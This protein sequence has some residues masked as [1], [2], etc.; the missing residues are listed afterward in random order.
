MDGNDNDDDLEWGPDEQRRRALLLFVAHSAQGF[1]RSLEWSWVLLFDALLVWYRI[2]SHQHNNAFYTVTII[3][4]L[5]G[6][7]LL[8]SYSSRHI[9]IKR[10]LA[11][12]HWQCHLRWWWIRMTIIMVKLGSWDQC[13]SLWGIKNSEM[14]VCDIFNDH[15]TTERVIFT[16]EDM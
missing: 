5:N 2:C 9:L 8:L 1:D 10:G 12:R 7:W 6:T 16:E 3:M 4:E 11:F 14:L 13:G 15:V